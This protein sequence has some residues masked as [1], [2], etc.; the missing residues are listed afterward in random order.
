MSNVIVFVIGFLV[1]LAV[2]PYC[3]ESNIHF[4]SALGLSVMFKWIWQLLR[5]IYHH[6]RARNEFINR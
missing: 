2:F 3:N 6:R 4:L 1:G 5:C